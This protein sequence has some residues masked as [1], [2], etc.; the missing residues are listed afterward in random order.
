M[1]NGRTGETDADAS[2]PAW[3][4][5]AH[6]GLHWHTR[7]IVNATIWLSIIKGTLVTGAWLYGF[8]VEIGGR[9]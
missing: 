4:D 8:A 2:E 9:L 5:W 7:V 3:W 1:N 6:A